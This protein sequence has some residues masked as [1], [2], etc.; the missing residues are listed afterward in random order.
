[1]TFRASTTPEEADVYIIAV[2]TPNNNDEFKS[3]DISIVMAGVKSIVPLL[4]KGDTVIVE[5]TI[6]HG[7]ME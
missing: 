5:S 1:M 3:C 6:A 4:K 2:P 7:T